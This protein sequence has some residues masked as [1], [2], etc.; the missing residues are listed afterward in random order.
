MIE[1]KKLLKEIKKNG[2]QLQILQKNH[3]DKLKLNLERDKYL[4]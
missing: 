1:N 2:L 4:E 3:Q